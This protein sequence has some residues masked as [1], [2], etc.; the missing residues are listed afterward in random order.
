MKLKLSAAL[1][2][3]WCALAMTPASADTI[4]SYTGN[5]DPNTSN[6]YLTA[7]VDLICT[8]PC[9]AG[10]YVEGLGIANYSITVYDAANIPLQSVSYTTSLPSSFTRYITLDSLGHV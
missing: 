8:S 3:A 1:T 6:N 2:A 5:P 7:T 10:T 4:Y 9:A